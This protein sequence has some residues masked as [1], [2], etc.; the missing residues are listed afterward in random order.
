MLASGKDASCDE[1][2]EHTSTSSDGVTDMEVMSSGAASW[3]APATCVQLNV[4]VSMKP[5]LSSPR[6][7]TES[8]PP[9]PPTT[10][11]RLKAH[12]QCSG[13]PVPPLAPAVAG[14]ACL[15]SP[16]SKMHTSPVSV[17]ATSFSSGS[18]QWSRYVCWV[19]ALPRWSP[20]FHPLSCPSAFRHSFRNLAPL[21]PSVLESDGLKLTRVTGCISLLMPSTLPLSHSHTTSAWS[22]A[23]PRAASFFP[24]A[25]KAAVTNS[26]DCT[27]GQVSVLCRRCDCT[28]KIDTCADCSPRSHTARYLPRVW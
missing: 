26:R 27:S 16:C 22:G 12:T 13:L 6:S 21:L 3:L 24:S 28:W 2:H 4:C 17:H 14:S 23:P 11:P 20:R 7:K 8:T 25:E 9:A 15:N 19:C 10:K 1:A 5:S 18:Q